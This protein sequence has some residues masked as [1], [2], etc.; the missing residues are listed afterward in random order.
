MHFQAMLAQKGKCDRS[1]ISELHW[2]IEIRRLIKGDK[3]GCNNFHRVVVV[4]E[5]WL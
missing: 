2:W 5:R 3:V 4:V 1:G